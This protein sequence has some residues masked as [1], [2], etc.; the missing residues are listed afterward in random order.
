[1]TLNKNNNTNKEIIVK[2]INTTIGTSRKNIQKITKHIIDIIIEIMLKENKI[3]ITNFGKFSIKEKKERIGRNP[4]TG[5][6]Y[7]ITK[8][9]VV[10]FK[11]SKFL[12]K[13]L[14]NL[15]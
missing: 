7:K 9:N 11:I 12:S 8:R 2:D 13:K 14:N 1:M 10:Q 3:N 6:N 15:Y 5:K 4:I